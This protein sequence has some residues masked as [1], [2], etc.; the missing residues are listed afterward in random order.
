MC[1]ALS[2]IFKSKLSISKDL[3]QEWQD[4]YVEL[5]KRMKYFDQVAKVLKYTSK[6]TIHAP[7]VCSCGACGKKSCKRKNQICAIW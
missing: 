6:K 7:I 2:F 3:F 4:S 5:L 1:F